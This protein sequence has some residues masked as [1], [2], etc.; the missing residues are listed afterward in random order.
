M[1]TS[2]WINSAVIAAP[3]RHPWWASWLCKPDA[4]SVMERQLADAQRDLA[5]HAAL[6][7]YHSAMR[8]M[9]RER[10]VRLIEELSN[11]G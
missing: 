2:V 6:T 7:E 11:A 9:L 8:D 10:C 3:A 4:V 5:S 1:N